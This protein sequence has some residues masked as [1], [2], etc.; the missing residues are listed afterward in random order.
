MRRRKFTIH[1]LLVALGACAGCYSPGRSGVSTEAMSTSD[2]A[3]PNP[4]RV[5]LLFHDRAPAFTF[6]YPRTV[7][8]AMVNSAEKTWDFID[9]D[10]GADEIVAGLLVSG[11]AGIIGGAITGVSAADIQRAEQV[12]QRALQEHSIVNGISNQIQFSFADRGRPSPIIIPH[13]LAAGLAEAEPD[14]R[15]YGPV[16]ALGVDSVM[17]LV[18]ASYGFR[19][20][21]RSNPPMALEAAVVVRVTR[22]SDTNTLVHSVIRY[23][24]HQHRFMRWAAE[25][26]LQ[27]KS[28]LKRIGRMVGRNAVE[29]AF[30]DTPADLK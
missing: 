20:R 19:A 4:G 3:R 2:P 15:D 28:D 10:D 18:V 11:M 23:H 29:V 22:L 8:D 14:Q 16:K 9:L 12:M 6:R 7:G 25:D 27:F 26:A 21:E 13:E 30:P 17:E 24:G 5:G 1:L